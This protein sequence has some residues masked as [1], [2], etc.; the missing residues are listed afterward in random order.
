MKN[1][2]IN[3]KKLKDRGIK[4]KK[5]QIEEPEEIVDRSNN[6]IPKL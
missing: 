1:K 2:K 6:K 3:H 4:K 5:K